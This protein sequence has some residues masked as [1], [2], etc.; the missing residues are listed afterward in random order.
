M[1]TIHQLAAVLALALL[2]SPVYAQ[3]D[4]RQLVELPEMMQQHMLGN[5]RD[6]LAT[7]NAV[8]EALASAD[9][10]KAAELA[11]TRLGMSSLSRHGASHMAPFMPEKMRKI[12]TQM[13]HKASQFAIISRESAVTQD[14]RRP[15]AALSQITSQ[16]IA[17]HT[18][19][20]IH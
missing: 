20:R 3:P 2:G 17:C 5:M 6:H 15:L 12:G 16:C 14:L 13:H 19:Y 11:E 10:D 18:A 9:F 7:L 4:T 1:R 8:H